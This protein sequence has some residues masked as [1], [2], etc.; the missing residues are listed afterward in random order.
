MFSKSRGVKIPNYLLMCED[1]FVRIRRSLSHQKCC[2]CGT[3]YSGS[4]LGKVLA[5][6]LNP[7]LDHI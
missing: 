5:P 6:D 1:V 3:I 2:R 7:D 4:G